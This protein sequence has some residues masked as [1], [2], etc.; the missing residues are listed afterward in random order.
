V[1]KWNIF[2]VQG[3]SLSAGLEVFQGAWGNQPNPATISVIF[4]SGL[5][6]PDFLLEMDAIPIVPD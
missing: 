3:Q 5:A 2:V 1:I 4:V 6:H